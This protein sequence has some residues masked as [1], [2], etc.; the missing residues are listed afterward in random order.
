MFKHNKTETELWVQRTGEQSGDCQREGGWEGQR[1]K[2]GRLRGCKKKM[3]DR[4]EMYSV[5]NIVNNYVISSYDN[6]MARLIMAIILKGVEISNHFAVQWELIQCC[7]SLTCQKWT[8][9]F[10]EKNQSDLW[11]LG[12]REELDEDIQKVQIS[13][14][15]INKY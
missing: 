7:R 6:I 11:L 14:Y 12:V 8:N 3:S 4:Y 1:T 13:S 10:I 2:W 9:R 5:G 15:K